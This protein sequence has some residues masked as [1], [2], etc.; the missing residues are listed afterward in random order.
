MLLYSAIANLKIKDIL[1]TDSA[2]VCTN[3]MNQSIWAVTRSESGRAVS[4]L[5]VDC[6]TLLRSVYWECR[7]VNE[8]VLTLAHPAEEALQNETKGGEMK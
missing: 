5:W 7:T 3:E 8:V 6:P 1:K 4:S 2:R